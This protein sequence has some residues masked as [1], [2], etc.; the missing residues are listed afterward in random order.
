MTHNPSVVN[1]QFIGAAT[2]RSMA[3]VTDNWVRWRSYEIPTV[4]GTRYAVRLTAIGGSGNIQP[5]KR[6]KDGNSYASGR[7]YDAQGNAQNF[8]LNIMVFS[9]NDGTIVTMNKRTEGLGFMCDDGCFGT[10]WGQ[11]FVA[12]GEGL[13][14]ADVWAAGAGNRWDLKFLWR[15]RQGGQPGPELARTRSQRVRFKAPEWVCT[16]SA[17]I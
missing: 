11:T 1:W 15:V 5:Y 4:A 7:A 16:G 13:A 17:I 9:D 10:R 14:G 12:K 2:D 6:D 3:D 8:D